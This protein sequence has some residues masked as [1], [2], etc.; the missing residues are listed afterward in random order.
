MLVNIT[1]VYWY[2][3][4]ARKMIFK[5]KLLII[6]LFVTGCVTTP[7]N[8]DRTFYTDKELISA[9]ATQLMGADIVGVLSGNTLYGKYVDHSK[10]ELEGQEQRWVE[11]ISNDGRV[12]YYN[13]TKLVQGNW[14]LKT[15]LICFNYQLDIPQPENC[16]V[17]YEYGD[18]QYFISTRQQTSGQVV[19]TVLGRKNGNVEGLDIK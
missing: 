3:K 4:G 14:I 18:K 5:L 7:I 13:F 1:I 9:G 12:A 11:F 8:T 2:E 19:S 16:F 15:N 6:F 10:G 17:V